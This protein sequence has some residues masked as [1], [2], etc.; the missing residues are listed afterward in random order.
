[1]ENYRVNGITDSSAALVSNADLEKETKVSPS[2][3]SDHELILVVLNVKRSRPKRLGATRST[4]Q[5][6]LFVTI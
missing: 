1:M 3:I 5:K 2:S 6:H 4:S